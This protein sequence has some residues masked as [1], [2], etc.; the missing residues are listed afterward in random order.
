MHGGMMDIILM[1]ID[2]G[3]CLLFTR[4]FINK[5]L[6]INIIFLWASF[7]FKAGMNEGI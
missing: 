1:C 4:R 2:G 3:G 7:F 6:V 5:S